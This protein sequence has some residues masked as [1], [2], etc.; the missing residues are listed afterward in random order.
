MLKTTTGSS[1]DWDDADFLH[2]YYQIDGGGFQNLVWFENDG[3]GN[4]R[5]PM[6]DTDFDGTGDG[7]VLTD[8]FTQFSA[9]ISGSG[10]LLDLRVEFQLDGANEDIAFDNFLIQ[11]VPEPGALALLSLISLSLAMSRRRHR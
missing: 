6:L 3:G 5:V 7:P 2:I 8:A 1:Q 9:S 11:S 10:S 4:D